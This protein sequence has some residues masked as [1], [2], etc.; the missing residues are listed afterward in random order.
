[1]VYLTNYLECKVAKDVRNERVKELCRVR[2]WNCRSSEG[3]AHRLLC[4]PVVKQWKSVA[5]TALFPHGCSACRG[6]RIGSLWF[7]IF[8]NSLLEE[9]Q[10][11]GL[12]W[13]HTVHPT[14]GFQR[15]MQRP[16]GVCGTGQLFNFTLFSH[17]GGQHNERMHGKIRAVNHRVT[18]DLILSWYFPILNCFY[19]NKDSMHNMLQEQHLH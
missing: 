3:Q 17:V 14:K 9:T 10:L 4:S 5:N 7:T 15:L 19:H 1:M 8:R 13:E 11:S 12:E 18:F 16:P 2:G 6:G